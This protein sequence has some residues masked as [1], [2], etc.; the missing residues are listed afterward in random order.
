MKY[1]TKTAIKLAILFSVA[2]GGL[3]YWFIQGA[4]I[5]QFI[6]AF[7]ML[8]LVS[9]IANAG[10]HRWLTHNQFQPTWLG[11][12]IMLYFMVL[13]GEAPPGHYVIAHLNHHKYTDE[14]GDPHGP[15]QIG[16]WNLTL[17]RY[18]E[19]KPVFM[20]N[21]ARNKDAQWVTE[22][23]WSLYLAN[24]ILFA[25]I[26]P[27]LNVWLACMFCWSW[28]QMINLNWRGHGGTKGTPTNL[29]RISN[30]FMGGEDYHKNHHENP[31]KLVMGK[32][33]TTGK[34]L[35]PWLLAK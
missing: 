2:I 32:W 21:Y 29:G 24:W 9:R 1:T 15:K 34:Y 16:F 26:N 35:V 31:G 11:K 18:G 5:W 19:T 23:Y 13:T 20:R 10:Y 6:F 3:A 27:Y 22:H 8:S 4:T 14:E 25:L 7:I 12:N 28:L 33:D 17:G 30:L